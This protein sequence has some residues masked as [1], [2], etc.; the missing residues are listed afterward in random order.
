VKGKV[1]IAVKYCRPNSEVEHNYTYWV[2][3]KSVAIFELGTKEYPFKRFDTPAREV[4]N[5]M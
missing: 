3:S 4:L 1:G 5:F 2:N